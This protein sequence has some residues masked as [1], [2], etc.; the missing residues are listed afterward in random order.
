MK[1]YDKQENALSRILDDMQI[2]T[3]H[4]DE[5]IKNE[6]IKDT[7]ARDMLGFISLEIKDFYHAINEKRT[8]RGNNGQ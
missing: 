1:R 5:A 3:S 7:P 6:Y 4:I 2:T 8:R